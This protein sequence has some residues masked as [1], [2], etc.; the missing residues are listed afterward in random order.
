MRIP[1]PFIDEAHA[2]AISRRWWRAALREFFAWS[3]C[4]VIAVSLGRDAYLSLHPAPWV[5]ECLLVGS[6]M[7]LNRA[8]LWAGFLAGAAI[9]AGHAAG[10][11]FSDAWGLW[12]I[13]LLEIWLLCLV[14]RGAIRAW[15]FCR[16]FLGL[17][18]ST[19]APVRRA[20]LGSPF[21]DPSGG[22]PPDY[23]RVTDE[24]VY[25]DGRRERAYL[26]FPLP[27]EGIVDHYDRSNE[28]HDLDLH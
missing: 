1:S 3:V 22:I 4:V 8:A 20:G 25:C 5:N 6:L 27:R 21:A 11:P 19:A 2:R 15:L 18:A 17:G 7:L 14:A 28:N 24:Y 13:R 23:D 26:N 16:P 9:Q 10:I 12:S